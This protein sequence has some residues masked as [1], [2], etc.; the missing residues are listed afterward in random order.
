MSVK[1][2]E[3]QE[4]SKVA[5]TIEVGAEEFEAAV[6]KAYL[7]MR[8]K[9]NISGFRPGK[10]PRK[11]IEGMYGTEVFYEEAVNI[12]LPDAYEAA[13]QEEK[14]E[15]V[16]Y[17]EVELV[18]CGK[19][20]V[21]FKTT[22]A[23]YP[24]VKL[25]QY[26]GLEAPKAEV[27][28]MAAD[29]N[30]RL[31]EMSERNARLVSVERAVEKGDTAVIDFEGFDNGVAFD[32]GKGENFDLEIG[33]GGFVPGFEDQI[34]GM[35]AG[36][37]KD[38]DITFPENY[39]P[40]L[41]G[42]PVVF[43]VKVN[44]VK[45]KEVP[46]IDDEFAKDVSEFDSLKELKADLKK[47]ITAEREEAA[48][49]AFEDALMQKVADGVEC[50]IPD[51]MIKMQS[52]KMCEGFKQQLASQGIPFE[53]Y[54]Q[55]TNSTEAAFVEEAKEPATQQIRMDLAV[56]AI[57]KAENLEVSD[58][59]VEAEYKNLSEKYNMD[60]D[61][62]KKYLHVEQIKEQVIREKA[63]KVVADSAVAVA[64]EEDKSEE[65]AE[66]EETKTAKK[67]AKKA[68]EPAESK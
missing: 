5:L 9:M 22:V 61:T 32:G 58:E 14:L 60:V 29:V 3:K 25:G 15:T 44:E 42:K 53:Q 59:E 64:P 68:E 51:D 36:E 20:G 33:S 43:H 67:S 2:C 10:A 31:K 48:K 23:V 4:K 17:P 38:I 27:K 37:E 56:E 11:I 50:E 7:K 45:N 8:G 24:E 46:A 39:T 54:L 34:I 47:K 30:N 66:D 13:V 6:N 16:G 35:Q 49:R 65:S 62:V 19:E 26:K 40:E 63:I 1:S 52:E 21:T 55:M 18:S 28:V 12:L 41:A 57:V